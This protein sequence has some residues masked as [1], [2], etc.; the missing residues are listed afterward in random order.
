[1]SS[2]TQVYE[3]IRRDGLVI[4]IPT[5]RY[6]VPQIVDVGRPQKT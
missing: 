4:G 2:V 5:L 3:W 1:M 6:I